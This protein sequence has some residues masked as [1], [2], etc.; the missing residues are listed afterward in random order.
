MYI[1]IIYMKAYIHLHYY[2]HELFLMW[3]LFRKKL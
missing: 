1:Y 3:K 2:L